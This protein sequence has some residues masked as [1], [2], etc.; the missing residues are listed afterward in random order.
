MM[1]RLVNQPVIILLLLGDR[2]CTRCF[3]LQDGHFE[4]NERKQEETA[5]TWESQ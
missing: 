5:D 4:D 1:R 3:A 2:Y